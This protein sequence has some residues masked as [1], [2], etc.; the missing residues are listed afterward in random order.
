MKNEN[1]KIETSFDAWFNHIIEIHSPDC[2]I[3]LKIEKG[4]PILL[5][6]AN[7]IY[8]LEICLDKVKPDYLG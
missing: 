3:L 6:A 2:V 7:E 4:R 5:G 1:N 8:N